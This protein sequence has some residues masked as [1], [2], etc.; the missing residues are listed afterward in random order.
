MSGIQT[1]PMPLQVA[2]SRRRARSLL[3]TS[4]L[5]NSSSLGQG[6]N[7][8]CSNRRLNTAPVP[9]SGNCSLD[10]SAPQE[11]AEKRGGHRKG[12]LDN[13][14][15]FPHRL[16]SSSPVAIFHPISYGH[17]A[18][19]SLEQLSPP[20]LKSPWS[21][22]QAFQSI[23]LSGELNNKFIVVRN[24]SIQFEWSPNSEQKSGPP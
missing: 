15:S 4:S 14:V 6:C 10:K 13:H 5:G 11:S 23:N 21:P 18:H 7:R 17:A 2:D 8:Q 12:T 19:E 3:H 24:A 22:H 20:D 9:T 16:L 1:G